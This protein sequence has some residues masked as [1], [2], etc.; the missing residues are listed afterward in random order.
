MVSVIV[1]TFNSSETVLD[2][3]DSIYLQTYTPLELIVSDD[4][5]KDNTIEKVNGWIDSHQERFEHVQVIESSENTGVAPNCNRGFS[6]AKG[7]FVQIIAGD[8][9]LLPN[10]IAEKVAFAENHGYDYVLC[11]TEPFGENQ[12][13][14]KAVQKWCE[15]GYR[16]IREGYASQLDHIFCDNFIA[17]PSGAFYRSS[18]LRGF[19]GFDEDYP[20]LEDYPFI[21]RYIK[22][23]NELYLL[24]KVL[25]KYRISNSSLS[26]A[27]KNPRNSPMWKCHWDFFFKERLRDLIKRG[28]IKTAAYQLCRYGYN[29]FILR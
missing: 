10:A 7:D 13:N 19:G 18:F 16:I 14:V 8:D 24:D 17:G 9:L 22:N 5:S 20:M 4:H 27:S 11:K 1:V 3:L 12:Q 25:S 21:Y 29:R 2:T 6:V 23:G 28:E 15:E 26:G